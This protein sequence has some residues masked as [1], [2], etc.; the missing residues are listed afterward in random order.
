MLIAPS[1]TSATFSVETF[2]AQFVASR[3]AAFSLTSLIAGSLLCGA[4]RGQRVGLG[5]VDS[6]RLVEAG[7][8]E[9]LAVMAR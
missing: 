8:L 4:R 9:D 3:A 6:D 5:V 1:G 2:L 7:Q